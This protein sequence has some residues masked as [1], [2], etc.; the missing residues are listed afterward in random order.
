MYFHD[1]EARCFST[2]NKYTG[3]EMIY[4]TLIK[5][6]KDMEM[7]YQN[8]L[9]ETMETMEKRRREELEA[10]D[11]QIFIKEKEI[12]HEKEKLVSSSKTIK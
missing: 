4:H 9:K 12:E 7:E 10:K 5:K 11:N 1:L 8:K 3:L 6:I 2:L